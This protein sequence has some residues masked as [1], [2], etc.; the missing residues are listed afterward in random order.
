MIG[1]TEWVEE[2]ERYL[3][4]KG[5]VYIN[6]DISVDGNETLRMYGS[7]LMETTVFK[8]LKEV[9]D[10]HKNDSKKM[11]V[12]ERMAEMNWYGENKPHF[13]RLLAAS[14]YAAF[15]EF[16]GKFVKTL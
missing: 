3:S 13:G 16:I 1:S 7:P 8:N 10:P 9:E 2:N 12:Y 6:V 5:V 15:Y 14:D 11:T 4:S